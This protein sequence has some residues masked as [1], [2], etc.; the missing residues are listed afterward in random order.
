MMCTSV[1]LNCISISEGYPLPVCDL[2]LSH[3]LDN[4][5]TG[6]CIITAAISVIFWEI[7]NSG[8]HLDVC[9]VLGDRILATVHVDV[10][11]TRTKLSIICTKSAYIILIGEYSP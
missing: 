11:F 8:V 5:H 6:A 4:D 2:S 10:C 9:R 3:L 1:S 7:W